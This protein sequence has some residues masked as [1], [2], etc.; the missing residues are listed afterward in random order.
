MLF[1]GTEI[2]WLLSCVG[3]CLGVVSR[4]TRTWRTQVEYRIRKSDLWFDG[5]VCSRLPVVWCS[6]WKKK[7]TV[8]LRLTLKVSSFFMLCTLTDL[9]L[10]AVW[11]ILS[12]R[13]NHSSSLLVH[14]RILI[15]SL[16][17][18]RAPTGTHNGDEC[19]RVWFKQM[20]AEQWA[21]LLRTHRWK[22]GVL[23]ARC[24]RDRDQIR[25]PVQVSS[26][27]SDEV[28]GNRLGTIF[29]VGNTFSAFY[30]V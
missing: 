30:V 29:N 5:G 3:F 7:K 6:F 19:K 28:R 12:I 23:H 27:K 15:P 24:S 21:F 2:D 20:L 14:S 26:T 9:I 22:C 17:S 1:G 10:S 25:L 4:C 16:V 13:L 11:G 8:P 18:R